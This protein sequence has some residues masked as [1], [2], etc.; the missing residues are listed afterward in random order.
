MRGSSL[1][2]NPRSVGQTHQ[3]EHQ[4]PQDTS[5]TLYRHHP[6]LVHVLFWHHVL[7]RRFVPI[8][9]A[10]GF[11]ANLVALDAP[12]LITFFFC[13][14]YASLSFARCSSER[15][16]C[17]QP[18]M[19]VYIQRKVPPRFGASYREMV[20]SDICSGE[21]RTAPLA[22]CVSDVV[23]GAPPL[24][25][26]SQPDAT[27][28]ALPSCQRR[29]HRR[30]RTLYSSLPRTVV[31]LPQ[32][33]GP[34]RDPLVSFGHSS[35]MRNAMTRLVAKI[36]LVSPLMA[37]GACLQ[38]S[39]SIDTTALTFS[40]CY[41]QSMYAGLYETLV[42][43]IEGR[44]IAPTGTKA[45]SASHVSKQMSYIGRSECMVNWLNVPRR[46]N[47]VVSETSP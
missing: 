10:N 26:L 32:P 19:Y 18:P 21:K 34:E 20:R 45:I 7:L 3:L 42:W 4:P 40:G 28:L 24:L 38:P 9:C 39:L 15:G 23:L 6:S 14:G 36:G 41:Q 13:T 25:L 43:T 16:R 31:V 1:P 35:A 30:S 46:A 44:D 33:K 11:T 29:A 2:F 5:Q 12:R 37:A 17:W 27:T 22:V 47:Y 8:I